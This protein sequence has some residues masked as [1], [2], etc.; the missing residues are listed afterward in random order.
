MLTSGV[1]S[2]STY[3]LSWR[4]EKLVVEPV[5]LHW[6]LPRYGVTSLSVCRLHSSI[7]GWSVVSPVVVGKLGPGGGVIAGSGCLVVVVDIC[8]SAILGSGVGSAI[9]DTV[10]SRFFGLLSFL[11]VG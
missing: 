8:V 3:S 4:L 10:L 9:L 2:S 7:G 5:F 11:C 6:Q 1:A